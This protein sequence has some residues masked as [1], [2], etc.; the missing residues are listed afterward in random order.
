MIPSDCVTQP[1]T[2][3]INGAT[4]QWGAV[5]LDLDD[6]VSTTSQKPT[7]FVTMAP[8]NFNTVMQH[9]LDITSSQFKLREL[10]FLG[11]GIVCFLIISIISCVYSHHLYKKHCRRD[12]QEE[13]PI[14]LLVQR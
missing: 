12:R 9:A 5:S 3:A 6:E 4:N 11:F 7:A 10:L 1:L 14:P 2:V 8:T 13:A